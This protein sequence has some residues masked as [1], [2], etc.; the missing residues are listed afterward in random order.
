MSDVIFHP[1]FWWAYEV[2]TVGA[3]GDTDK[4]GERGLRKMKLVADE[5]AE[6]C[7]DEEEGGEDEVDGVSAGGFEFLVYPS[8]VWWE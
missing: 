4:S 7:V 5:G 6:E 3:K 1:P 2:G 8:H